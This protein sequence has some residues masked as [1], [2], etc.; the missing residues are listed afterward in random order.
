MYGVN[1]LLQAVSGIDY[2]GASKAPMARMVA[3]TRQFQAAI[4]MPRAPMQ[5]QAAVDDGDKEAQMQALAQGAAGH[6]Q[7][8]VFLGSNSG[9]V[10]IVAGAT[11][12]VTS[13][14][15]ALLRITDLIVSDGIANDFDILSIQVGRLNLLA[16]GDPIPASMFRSS[17]QR[18]PIEVPRLHPGQNISITVR[19]NA[20]AAR[21][22]SA[23]FVGIDLSTRVF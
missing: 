6:A 23:S 22:W 7:P 4:P 21:T 15:G 8:Q 18:P 19:N 1:D 16:S 12:V 10:P 9:A 13:S 17:V 2:V 3:P 11:A 14:S 20:G 5:T